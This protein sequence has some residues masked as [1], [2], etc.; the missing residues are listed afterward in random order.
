MT[1]KLVESTCE[2]LAKYLTYSASKEKVCPQI[3]NMAIFALE[4]AL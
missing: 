1:A 2:M 3:S 4:I